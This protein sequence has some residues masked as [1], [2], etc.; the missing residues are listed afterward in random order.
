MFKKFADRQA[1]KEPRADK[2]SLLLSAPASTAAEAYCLAP[3]MG[4]NSAIYYDHE[5]G[6]RA[7]NFP[8]DHGRHYGMQSDWYFFVGV[9]YD[10]TQ[11][12]NY[13]FV[14]LFK[15]STVVGV[16]LLQKG[17]N[18]VDA[19]QEEV[20]FMFTDYTNNV[21]MSSI[22]CWPARDM[23]MSASPFIAETPNHLFS[24]KHIEDGTT[25][26]F[27]LQMNVTD[28]NV[29][30]NLTCKTSTNQP[31]LQGNKGFVGLPHIGEGWGY[32]SYPAIQ[33]KGTVSV[34]GAP[35]DVDGIGWFDHQWG[36]IGSS[37]NFL[38]RQ[39]AGVSSIFTG[40]K[41]GFAGWNWFC[42][43]FND[44][45]FSGAYPVQYD[46]AGNVVY[47]THNIAAYANLG[48][49]DG[50]TRTVKGQ[51]TIDVCSYYTLKN[52]CIPY[53]M[54]WKFNLA[55]EELSFHMKP[56][57]AGQMGYH[58]GGLEFSENACMIQGIYKGQSISGIGWAE[59]VGY[60]PQTMTLKQLLTCAK[61]PATNAN[62]D[63]LKYADHKQNLVR[64]RGVIGI[65]TLII[66]VIVVTLILVRIGIKQRNKMIK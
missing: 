59:D 65:I 29:V 26:I 27:P 20:L 2:R 45:Y 14:L 51:V 62:I 16:K 39:L 11:K 15:S 19:A 63:I 5:Q 49:P 57:K 53:P 30:L 58:V 35:V 40:Y 13:S 6:P 25:N 66:L 12:F 36:T 56:Y 24:L 37:S 34:N 32:Y 28:K 10:E 61:L 41:G 31:F 1:G 7:F 42:A 17:E 22:D 44:M 4:Q 38:V 55:E 23:T 52:Q 46:A 48:F 54:E 64:G 50:T 60:A 8:A 18:I 21:S 43:I 47:S 33:Y 3:L 9:L